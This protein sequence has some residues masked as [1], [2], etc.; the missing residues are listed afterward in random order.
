MIK[1]LLVFVFNRDEAS[2]ININHTTIQVMQLHLLA[3]PTKII[4]VITMATT[5]TIVTIIIVITRMVDTMASI[6]VTVIRTTIS[7]IELEKIKLTNY[8]A[9]CSHAFFFFAMWNWSK[10]P[11]VQD[12]TDLHDIH[13]HCKSSPAYNM[14]FCYSQ[15]ACSIPGSTW[16]GYRDLFQCYFIYIKYVLLCCLSC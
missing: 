14:P 11:L 16:L 15:A 10:L 9:F 2:I 12:V 13:S 3:I 8:Y 1:F 6:A 7:A 4:A 5:A